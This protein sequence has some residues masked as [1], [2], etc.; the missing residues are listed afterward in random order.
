[1][2]ALNIDLVTNTSNSILPVLTDTVRKD[3]VTVS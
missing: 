2:D 1:M 3:M